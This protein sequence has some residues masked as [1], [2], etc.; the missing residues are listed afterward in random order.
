MDPIIRTSGLVKR[1][2]DQLAV[3]NLDLTIESGTAVGLLG[4]NG[5]GKSTTINM[6]LGLV[7]PTRGE[8]S[9]LGLDPVVEGAAVRARVGYVPERHHIY[10]WMTVEEV[11]GF[12]RS[13]Y[14][15]W[16]DTLCEDLVR[17][18]ALP[19]QKKVKHLSQGMGT[20]LSLILA[21]AHEPELL[22]LDEPTTGLDPIA[23]DE[24]VEAVGELLTQYEKTI[25]FSS[26][27]LSDVE[28][29]ADTIAI[30]DAGALL[31]QRPRAELT[32]STKRVRVSLNGA[33]G[34]PAPPDGTVFDRVKDG[35]WLLTIGECTD[36]KLVQLREAH[37]Q[38]AVQ[39]DDMALEEIFRDY[40]RGR[41]IG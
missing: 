41:A 39:V 24:F 25:L 15:S 19:P 1:Y 40:V 11:L 22:I 34:S 17:R 18:Y 23:R 30:M 28:R 31:V 27:N 14:P 29:I 3:D 4:P 20:K 32:A 38:N 35:E 6:L 10:G 9:V 5:A 13:F 2:G 21:L 7:S 16:N 36:E 37:G 8:V 12:T 26:H 33:N